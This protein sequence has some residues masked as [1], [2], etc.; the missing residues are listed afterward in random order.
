MQR[1]SNYKF[2]DHLLKIFLKIIH[3]RIFKLHEEQ[4]SESQFSFRISVGTRKA[5]FSIQILFQR[6]RDIN[7]DVFP[8]LSSKI[9][10]GN[11]WLVSRQMKRQQKT[12]ILQG[13]RKGCILSPVIFKL[14][15]EYIYRE[16]LQD[17][18]AGIILNG[19]NYSALPSTHY[20]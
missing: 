19:V 13:V 17:I 18:E 6:C 3:S 20:E 10:T 1:V 11:R 14:Y 12:K 4:M 2:D 5:L 16:A 8:C 15:S 9:C 7:C